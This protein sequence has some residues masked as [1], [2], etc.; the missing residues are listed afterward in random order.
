LMS[1][2]STVYSNTRSCE[3]AEE[4]RRALLSLEKAHSGTVE[5]YQ[6]AII[7]IFHGL[8]TKDIVHLTS[9]RR[10]SLLKATGFDL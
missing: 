5:A 3:M 7:R 1:G 6:D 10:R 9:R 8:S 4:M 2:L